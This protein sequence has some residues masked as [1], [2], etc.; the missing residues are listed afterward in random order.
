M[1]LSHL[2]P[3]ELRTISRL[4]FTS[5]DLEEAPPPPPPRSALIRALRWGVADAVTQVCGRHAWRVCRGCALFA[6]SMAG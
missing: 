6:S 4:R 5:H 1:H 2:K 3:H